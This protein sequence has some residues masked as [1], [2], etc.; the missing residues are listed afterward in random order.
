VV[1]HIRDPNTL[2]DAEG[3]VDVG[4]AVAAAYG[5]RAHDGSR[6]DAIILLR[7]PEHALA[8]SIP[9]LGGEH[10]VAIVALNPTAPR[11]TDVATEVPAARGW[12]VPPARV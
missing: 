9:L 1:E 3:E 5:E 11:A 10:A 8:K 6:D 7:E 12:K 4:E 2:S